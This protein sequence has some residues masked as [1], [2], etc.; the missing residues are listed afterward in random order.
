MRRRRSVRTSLFI[1]TGSL[2]LLLSLPSRA[3]SKIQDEDDMTDRAGCYFQAGKKSEEH[4]LSHDS[5]S[6]GLIWLLPPIRST[7][8]S[9]LAHPPGSLVL[10]FL[11]LLLPPPAHSFVG[12]GSGLRRQQA[13]KTVYPSPHLIVH[14]TI[15]CFDPLT[16]L[17]LLLALGSSTTQGDHDEIG[18]S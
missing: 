1:R 17:L 9:Y 11:L 13:K 16:P 12:S 14:P 5:L 7:P 8:S 3:N 2:S 18:C 4:C 10:L 15:R 6:P